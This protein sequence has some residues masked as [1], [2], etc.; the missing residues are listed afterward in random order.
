MSEPQTPNQSK[1]AKTPRKNHRIDY[2]IFFFFGVVTIIILTVVA[3]KDCLSDPQI[4]F[5]QTILA[6]SVGG[7][8]TGVPGFLDVNYKGWIRAGGGLGAFVL[9]LLMKPLSAAASP[10]CKSFDLIVNIETSNKDHSAI[11][12]AQVNLR[13]GSHQIGPKTIH[14]NK[15]LFDRVPRE[16]F[17]D[18]IQLIPVD[19]RWQVTGQSHASAIESTEINFTIVKVVD[20]TVVSGYVFDHRKKAVENA[21]LV[22]GSKYKVLTDKSGFYSIKMPYEPGEAVRLLVLINNAKVEDRNQY[23]SENIDVILADK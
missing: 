13:I 6:I 8:V 1:T 23:I 16:F 20:S 19:K 3:M 2:V 12:N 11:N 9:V 14:E 17:A 15:V 7:L 5:F 18:S 22:F 21:Q 4:R 10:D